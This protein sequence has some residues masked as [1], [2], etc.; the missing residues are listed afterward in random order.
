LEH[1]QKIIPQLSAHYGPP[2]RPIS[3]DPFELI[4]FE[5]IAYL[6]SDERREAGVQ[7]V[8]PNNRD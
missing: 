2:R 4:L 7:L 6:V 3:T 8:A 1:L 5:N